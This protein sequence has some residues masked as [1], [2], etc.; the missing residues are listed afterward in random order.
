MFIS[1]LSELNNNTGVSPTENVVS[2]YKYYN[3]QEG[4][5]GRIVLNL[6]QDVIQFYYYDVTPVSRG[7]FD[8]DHLR[9]VGSI[10]LKYPK[11]TGNDILKFPQTSEYVNKE[12]IEND[13]NN[14][15][16]VNSCYKKIFHSFPFL[17]SKNDKV[18]DEIFRTFLKCCFLDFVI[19]IEDRNGCFAR[20][21][22]YDEIR[23]R[24]RQSEVYLLLSAKIKYVLMMQKD[25]GTYSEDEYDY[26]S[27]KFADRLMDG[28]INK[29][30]PPDYYNDNDFYTKE[31]W[32]YN[33]EDEL[34]RILENNRKQKRQKDKKDPPLLDKPLLSKIRSFM[35]TKHAIRY[36]MT[37]RVSG[38]LFWVIQFA[39]FLFNG[40]LLGACWRSYAKQ[41][42]VISNR[43]I[44]IIISIGAILLLFS[45][46]LFSGSSKKAKAGFSGWVNAWLPRVLVAELTA[47]FTIGSSEDLIKSMIV[48][49]NS[50]K[51]LILILAVV[52]LTIISFIICLEIKQHSPYLGFMK[53]AVR[54]ILV[55]NHSLFFAIILG[56]AVQTLFYGNLIKTSEVLTNVLFVDVFDKPNDYVSRLDTATQKAEIESLD[57]YLVRCQNL[58]T[59]MNWATYGCKP[60]SGSYHVDSLIN[61]YKKDRQFLVESTAW[62]LKIRI[63]P[64]LLLIHTV[65]VLFIAFVIQLLFSGK[66]VTEPL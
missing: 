6:N 9:E 15:S 1:E 40:I 20:L 13:A 22:Q 66:T 47:W 2:L 52:L 39:M 44:V 59:M 45:A 35:Y 50:S 14:F 51:F 17:D 27:Q 42:D 54:G 46:L 33:P 30:I 16:L 25:V 37:D 21:P 53:L 12:K 49:G 56:L 26:R 4:L 43:I 62:G 19:S 11:Y 32:F 48:G 41:T 58:D 18:N 55:V 5:D 65:I 31:K 7:V 38:L 29:V 63:F 28:R 34:E 57:V 36:A 3:G 8:Y 23:N 24:L 10:S 61:D 60:N 64:K